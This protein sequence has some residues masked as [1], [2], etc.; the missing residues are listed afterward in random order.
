MITKVD[1]NACARFLCYKFGVYWRVKLYF[2]SIC[3]ITP[4]RQIAIPRFFAEVNDQIINQISIEL[5]EITKKR[6]S[7]SQTNV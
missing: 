4:P 2:F 1:S 6:G 7:K 3:K 5:L